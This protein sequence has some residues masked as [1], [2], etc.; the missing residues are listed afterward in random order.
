MNCKK[1]SK[2]F[3]LLFAVAAFCFCSCASLATVKENRP[4]TF[5]TNSSKFVLLPPADIEKPIES[6]Q[7]LSASYGSRE[8]FLNV[9]VNADEEG[10]EMTILNEL[11]A[12]MGELS[13]SGGAVQ[14]TSAVFPKSIK[15]EYIV[16]DFQLCF[17]NTPALSQALKN[18]GLS[19]KNENNI[20]RI[21]QDNKL[22]IEIEKNQNKV[23]LKN[24]LRGYAYTLE[25]EFQ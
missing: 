12:N 2:L 1:K 10:I 15:P 21:Y 24:L 18:C 13:Y 14:F 6:F 4:F 23:K 9:W 20:R 17:Y 19:L 7:L 25:S 11:G 8:L 3:F 22:I 5:L 16:A